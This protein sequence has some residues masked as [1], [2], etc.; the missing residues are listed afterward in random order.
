M[1]HIRANTPAHILDSTNAKRE[2]WIWTT[3]KEEIRRL[4]QDVNCTVDA[5]TAAMKQPI[6]DMGKNKNRV[7]AKTV[8]YLKDQPLNV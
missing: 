5:C 6:I 2:E 7:K 1:N 3:F 8:E 4:G